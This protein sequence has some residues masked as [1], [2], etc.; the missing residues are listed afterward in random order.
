MLS[1]AL[2]LLVATGLSTYTTDLQYETL[3]VNKYLWH[4]LMTMTRF[5]Q[6]TTGLAMASALAFGGGDHAGAEQAQQEP[7]PR[8]H[9][10]CGSVVD[11]INPDEHNDR[12]QEVISTYHTEDGVDAHVYIL[13]YGE[14][15]GVNHRGDEGTREI[16]Q[17][18]RDQ[19]DKCNWDEDALV[20][21]LF[22]SPGAQAML[23]MGKA[24]DLYAGDDITDEAKA[25][26]AEDF[27]NPDTTP[28]EDV[29]VYLENHR[30]QDAEF[31]WRPVLIVG[32][33]VVLVVVAGALGASGS[34]SGLAGGSTYH[35][36]GYG[37]GYGGGGSWSS[38][39]DSGGSSVG[40][41]DL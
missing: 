15:Y 30:D 28:Q 32:G 2:L 10:D 13:P 7:G 26:L 34:G 1:C 36:G 31:P 33:I 4:D 16:G 41:G 21:A 11:D 39:G 19:A 5:I 9:A 12:L 14:S 20:L 38:G 22:A 17:F 6:A 35:G 18:L 3:A 24:E 23:T 25:T 29:A 37:Y 27:R 8:T 40:G